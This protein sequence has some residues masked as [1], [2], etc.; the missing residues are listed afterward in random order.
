DP[1]WVG[2]RAGQM[3]LLAVPALIAAG[4]SAPP[5]L[6]RAAGAVAVL[7]FLVG[8]PTTVVDVF[9]AQDIENLRPGPG[10]PWTQVVDPP[11][12][13]AFAW[14]RRSTAPDA[15]VQLDVAARNRTTWSIIPSF[16][17]RRMS[18]GD[19]RTLIEEPEYK[20][21][22]ERVRVMYSTPDVKAA[23]TIARG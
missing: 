13:E 22:S 21:R 16:A 8:L 6:R 12:A 14:L 9:N 11:H 18:A 5:P 17:E 20:E 19:P 15:T 4:L 2:F 1:S 10:F 7:T 3:V 23:W